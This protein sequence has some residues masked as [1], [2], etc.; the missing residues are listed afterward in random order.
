MKCGLMRKVVTWEGNQMT[1][2]QKTGRRQP[3]TSTDADFFADLQFNEYHQITQEELNDLIRDLDL[4]K[5][6]IKTAWG[7]PT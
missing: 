6:R 2:L 1:R 5:S 3:S 4:P 7:T